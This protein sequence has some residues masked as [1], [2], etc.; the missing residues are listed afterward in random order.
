MAYTP[1][2]GFA[3]TDY[4]NYCARDDKTDSNLGRVNI[5]VGADAANADLHGDG[6]ADLVERAFGLSVSRV[7][8]GTAPEIAFCE[9]DGVRFL[10]AVYDSK[11]IPPDLSVIF[12]ASSDLSGWDENA[13]SISTTTDA[14]GRTV[15]RVP[16]DA[17]SRIF[18]RYR[19]VR[20]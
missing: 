3:G 10:Q 19:V 7:S 6:L 17:Q 14:A 9:V 13:P 20:Q 18:L 2:P 11:L 16:V 12:E 8:R 4:F 15:K 1:N 5:E